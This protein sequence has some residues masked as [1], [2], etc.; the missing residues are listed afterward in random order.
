MSARKEQCKGKAPHQ[1]MGMAYFPSAY[2]TKGGLDLGEK[3]DGRRDTKEISVSGRGSSGFMVQEKCKAGQ[4]PN[5]AD[6]RG[7]DLSFLL[8]PNCN[9]VSPRIRQSS[10]RITF[11]L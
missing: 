4:Q 10:D 2:L 8:E 3:G 1:Q 9:E 11:G 6:I 5:R 7:T